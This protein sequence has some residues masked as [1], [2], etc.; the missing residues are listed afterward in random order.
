MAWTSGGVQSGT[1][2]SLS[3]LSGVTGVTTFSL[4]T[5]ITVYRVPSLLT[6]NGTLSW[7]PNSEWLWSVRGD[8]S[9]HVIIN[10]SLTIDGEITGNGDYDKQQPGLLFTG[11]RES[12]LNSNNADIRLNSGG[13]ISCTGIKIE[14]ASH[15]YFDSGSTA[16]FVRCSIQGSEDAISAS[17]SRRIRNYIESTFNEC[18]FNGIQ[19]DQFAPAS[20]ILPRWVSTY[21]ASQVISA[22]SGGSSSIYELSGIEIE[23][24]VIDLDNFA[25]SKLTLKN[26][27]QGSLFLIEHLNHKNSGNAL[28]SAVDGSAS[29]I[30]NTISFAIQDTS[31]AGIEDASVYLRDTNNDNRANTTYQDASSENFVDDRTHY[32]TSNGSGI[33]PDIDLLCYV[34]RGGR[35]VGAS[36]DPV[37]SLIH[38]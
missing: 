18:L 24:S 36:S 29:K 21:N 28:V 12:S 2:T 15:L 19:I 13:S 1:D 9:E 14:V 20:L 31:N 8:G 30:V 33:F 5:S 34:I 26:T 7:D 32:E 23:S 35:S 11:S 22:V 17:S 4:P 38:I 25:G 37:L 16:S 3:G 27:D 6:I 10:G